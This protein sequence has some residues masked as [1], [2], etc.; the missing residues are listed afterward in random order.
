[1]SWEYLLFLSSGSSKTV[2]IEH[3]KPSLYLA[4]RRGE[5]K[6]YYHEACWVGWFGSIRFET[7]LFGGISLGQF[8]HYNVQLTSTLVLDF[9]SCKS[10][11]VYDTYRF[12]VAT[13]MQFRTQEHELWSEVLSR[14]TMVMFFVP[15]LRII[16]LRC[17]FLTEG[18]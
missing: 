18:V 11:Y 1:M 13:D 3:G 6:L 7:P 4:E 14:S 16:V 8:V 2:S 15:S 9:W 10:L 5:L 12:I 17:F